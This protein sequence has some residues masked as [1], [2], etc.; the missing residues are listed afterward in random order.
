MAFYFH[1]SLEDILNLEHNNRRR[2]VKEI[3]KLRRVY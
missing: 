1:W 2:W 3:G